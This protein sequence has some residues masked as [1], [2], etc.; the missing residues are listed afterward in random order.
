[1]KDG[2]SAR[3]IK[4]SVYNFDSCGVLDFATSDKYRLLILIINYE[5]DTI[6]NYEKDSTTDKKMA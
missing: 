2:Y 3:F 1:M 4:Q 5:K 6:Q